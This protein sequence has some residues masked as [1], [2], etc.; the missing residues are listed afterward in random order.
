MI[1]VDGHFQALIYRVIL[2][3]CFILGLKRQLQQEICL[4]LCLK[5]DLQLV[6]RVILKL[7]LH[8]YF[9]FTVE[10]VPEK[11]KKLVA[12]VF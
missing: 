6:F 12:R 7:K 2:K 9:V 8:K 5:R 3:I 10:A 11:G 1:L 4:F